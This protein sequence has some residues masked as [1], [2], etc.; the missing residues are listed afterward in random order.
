M[1]KCLLSLLSGIATASCLSA[2][3]FAASPQTGDTAGALIPM[4]IGIMLVAV[5][6]MLACLFLFKKK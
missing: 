1:R 5:I 3:V 6:A 4:V 2:T